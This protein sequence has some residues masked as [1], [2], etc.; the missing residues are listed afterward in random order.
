MT[1][2]SEPASDQPLPLGGGTPDPW[3][4]KRL[5]NLITGLTGVLS[6]RVVATPLG[7]VS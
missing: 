4:M 1:S 2:S 3:G 5:E 7:E 6:A